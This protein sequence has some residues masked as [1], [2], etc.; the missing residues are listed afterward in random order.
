MC[1]LA[2]AWR[3][4]P[5]WRLVAAGNRD[6]LHARPSLPLARW[7]DVSGTIA[8][9][10][11][12]GGGTW[13]GVTETGRFAVVT[14]VREERGR[15]PAKTSRGELVSGVLQDGLATIADE[16]ER[17]NAFNLLAVDGG[18]LAL[19]SNRPAPVVRPL[20]AGVHGL[21][22]GLHDAPW[23]KTRALQAAVERWADN[24]GGEVEDL[25]AALRDER[26]FDDG[27]SDEA[28]PVGSP[29]FIRDPVYG[30]RC[31]TVVTVSREGRGM[32][33]E[34]RFGPDGAVTGETRL[35]FGW[36]R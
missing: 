3:T 14:N 35:A 33:A 32:I 19:V 4:T 26:R 5:K 16:L 9:R 36:V 25:F 17:F 10:D 23:P 7:D 22:N 18:A 15:D 6:E 13:L 27:A 31:S 20:Q 29:V 1:D 21:S 12:V 2:V 30:T 24:D 8:G 28:E 11:M 34:R